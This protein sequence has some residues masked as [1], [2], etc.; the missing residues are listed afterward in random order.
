MMSLEMTSYVLQVVGHMFALPIIH[1]LVASSVEEKTQARELVDDIVGVLTIPK[2]KF[3]HD[4]TYNFHV[5]G[6]GPVNE[7]LTPIIIIL[8]QQIWF[9]T[10]LLPRHLSNQS[11]LEG[12]G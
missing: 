4:D 9:S 2:T 10:N 1:D 7:V 6:T 8:S 3:V 5:F 11:P 12:E